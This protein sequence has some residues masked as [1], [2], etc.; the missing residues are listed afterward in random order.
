MQVQAQTWFPVGAEWTYTI[1]HPADD[2]T[3]FTTL[4]INCLRDTNIQ[5]IDA[6]I[7]INKTTL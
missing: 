1:Y 4:N 5:G 3:P 6:K 7:L 2:V